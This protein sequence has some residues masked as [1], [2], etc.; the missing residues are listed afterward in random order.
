MDSTRSTRSSSRRSSILKPAKPRQPLQNLNLNSSSNESS[1][2][3]KLKR[4]VSFA[5][6][7]HV[8]EFCNSVEQGTVWD[9][10]YE[11]HDLSNLKLLCA[12][13]GTERE[14]KNVHEGNEFNESCN[15]LVCPDSETINECSIQGN[16]IQFAS[17]RSIQ[18]DLSGEDCDLDFTNVVGNVQSVLV[19]QKE[20]LPNASSV[21]FYNTAEQICDSVSP[22][23]LQSSSNIHQTIS[24]YQDPCTDVLNETSEASHPNVHDATTYQD[25]NMD[26]TEIVCNVDIQ[27]NESEGTRKN[28]SM[29][30]TQPVKTSMDSIFNS[31]YS[32][33]KLNTTATEEMD[34]DV[35]MEPTVAIPSI[36]KSA[37]NND[38][39]EV[40]AYSVDDRT[41]KF[42]NVSM[43]ITSAVP[44]ILCNVQ[45]RNQVENWELNLGS[46]D[47]D[48]RSIIFHNTSMEMTKP[49]KISS[50]KEAPCPDNAHRLSTIQKVPKSKCDITCVDEETMEVT[51]AVAVNIYSVPENQGI[52][53]MR[54]EV[55][56]VDRNSGELRGGADSYKKMVNF[57]ET[58]VYDDE[59]MD[60]T[61]AIGAFPKERTDN[62]QD[63]E[64]AKIMFDPQ[65]SLHN[66]IPDNLRDDANSDRTRVFHNYSMTTTAVVSS[67]NMR[68]TCEEEEIDHES[69]IN[70]QEFGRTVLLP[71]IS[72]E[73]TE[74]VTALRNPVEMENF[75]DLAKVEES[76]LF[77]NSRSSNRSGE[78]L[79]HSAVPD[80]V[81]RDITAVVVPSASSGMPLNEMNCNVDNPRRF[82]DNGTKEPTLNE[83][84]NSVNTRPSMALHGLIEQD[85]C[86]S[87]LEEN[88]TPAAC[89]L[90]NS[91]SNDDT[92]AATSE[93]IQTE[94]LRRESSQVIDT[95]SRRT[96][97]LKP[98]STGH[99]FTSSNKENE[100]SEM[101]VGTSY[102]TD[103][104][105]N[106][107][108][109]F[110][111]I[112][113]LQGNECY[114]EQSSMEKSITFF[115][116]N[117]EELESIKPPSFMCLDDSL[118]EDMPVNVSYHQEVNRETDC[119]ADAVKRPENIECEGSP[120]FAFDYQKCN[121]VQSKQLNILEEDG[122]NSQTFLI[123]H[124]LL[125][126]VPDSSKLRL[127]DQ[128]P[129]NS[130]NAHVSVLEY[131]S[132]T[133]NDIE[134]FP[135]PA[136]DLEDMEIKDIG[137]D[138]SNVEA[139]RMDCS[140]E[141]K[142]TGEEA[143]DDQN[144]SNGMATESRESLE[145]YVLPVENNISIELDPFSKLTK[146]LKIRAQS[147]DIIWDVY[148]ENIEKRV[149]VIDFIA[150]SLLVAIYLDDSDAAS[151]Q[152]IKDIR[153]ISRLAGACKQ[154]A[155]QKYNKT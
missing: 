106:R 51:K 36:L 137:A 117:L 5:E 59:V 6:K 99:S 58:T 40:A 41:V 16:N 24:V 109:I 72:M 104:K 79:D 151:V 85:T 69:E 118:C 150:C 61:T 127:D 147:D 92:R 62:F 25:M 8:K 111:E 95:H 10:T 65:R 67:L 154:R 34:Q 27:G 46:S 22:T 115:D 149:F 50:C 55:T 123:K 23:D 138:S 135:I 12:P 28:T 88:N 96:Y 33:N 38:N 1:P 84:E 105:E 64:P 31:Q 32:I 146:E 113:N 110:N 116:N 81:L 19:T 93:V 7:K 121:L 78:S 153:I 76:P 108:H 124:T 20:Q 129:R 131:S 100:I 54:F 87:A 133:V 152:F 82:E 107:V 126:G 134:R 141:I 103:D 71:N 139:Q 102:K 94:S 11:E 56:A 122:C 45:Q 26:F 91:A 97:T 70:N 86:A 35:S 132:S 140:S 148:H 80:N 112:D 52:N 89:A 114:R 128:G 14:V 21:V 145:P 4:R 2:T 136:K 66:S 39:A 37:I 120:K 125:G 130:T 73:I 29:E 42:N 90:F 144:L 74:A 9:S 98:L 77:E 142:N 119:L 44:T 60:F 3:T 15:G 68:G 43:E 101:N 63:D 57:D 30:F 143:G 13:D 53:A 48:C 49:V 83:V 47:G 75:M 17:D 155:M 18:R